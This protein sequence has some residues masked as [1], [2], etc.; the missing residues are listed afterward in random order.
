MLRE[1]N[2]K[3]LTLAG[4][5]WC[6]LG[7]A[8]SLVF[9]LN[10]NLWSSSFVLWTAGWATLALVL[11]HVL[12]DQRGWPAI[13]RRFGVNAVTA[14]GGSE[15]MQILLLGLGIQGPLY[16]RAFAGWISPLAGPNVASLAFAIVFVAVWWVIV[17]AMDRKKI[18]LKL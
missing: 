5:A 9:P 14:Y 18:Y 4:I 7:F 11:F 13:G 12:I 16:Q 8:W 15:L 10:K 3:A 2:I 1:K 17:Y 6:V